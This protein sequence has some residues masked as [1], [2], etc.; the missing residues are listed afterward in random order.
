MYS[1]EILGR[2]CLARDSSAPVQRDKEEEQRR[3]REEPPNHKVDMLPVH[4]VA[5]LMN[6]AREENLALRMQI[7]ASRPEI[8][9]SAPSSED[10]YKFV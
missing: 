4:Q 10:R 1:G 2:R 7:R 8:I 5:A 9:P 3:T 6:E